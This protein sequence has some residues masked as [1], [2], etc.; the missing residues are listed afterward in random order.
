MLL[1]ELTIQLCTEIQKWNGTNDR[2]WVIGNIS[3]PQLFAHKHHFSLRNFFWTKKIVV[4][5]IFLQKFYDKRQ[6]REGQ[7]RSHGIASNSFFGAQA[8]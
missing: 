8:M 1:C 6:K 2:K 3:L 5:G 4:T 7:M